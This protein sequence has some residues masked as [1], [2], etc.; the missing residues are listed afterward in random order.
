MS[1]LL[2]FGIIAAAIFAGIFALA[3][4]ESKEASTKISEKTATVDLSI[5]KSQSCDCCGIYA[6]YMQK[7]DIFE[8]EVVDVP[9]MSAIKQR[10][11]IPANLQ[12]CHTSVVGNYFIEGHVPV[13]A[14]EKLLEEKPD[15]AGIA[16]P[17][18]PSGSPGMPGGKIGKFVVYA[19]AKDGTSSTFMEI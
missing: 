16:M 17:G 18:M 11:K 7:H 4:D 2:I 12:S 13:E 5:L 3:G 10:Y 8:T 1:K 9:D 14:I 19:V 6:K 15:I